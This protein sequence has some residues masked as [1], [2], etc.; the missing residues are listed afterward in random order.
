[1]LQVLDLIQSPNPNSA[2]FR[3]EARFDSPKL[4]TPPH[5][6]HSQVRQ[7]ARFNRSLTLELQYKE[8]PIYLSAVTRLPFG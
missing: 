7:S 3:H 6:A 4:A 8:S 5:L 2:I 1:M